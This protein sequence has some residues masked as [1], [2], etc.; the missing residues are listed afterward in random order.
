MFAAIFRDYF[1]ETLKNK[2]HD[3]EKF[4]DVFSDVCGWAFRDIMDE[5]PNVKMGKAGGGGLDVEK[6]QELRVEKV[7]FSTF[8]PQNSPLFPILNGSALR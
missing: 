2:E 6:R 1:V 8:F 5:L 4:N 3:D 7:G